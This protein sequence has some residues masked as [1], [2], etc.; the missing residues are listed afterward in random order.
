MQREEGVM[1][2][3]RGRGCATRMAERHGEKGATLSSRARTRIP[4]VG[5]ARPESLQKT[6]RRQLIGGRFPAHPD[7]RVGSQLLL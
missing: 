4:R 5:S 7:G 3:K 1:A 2:R 6:T